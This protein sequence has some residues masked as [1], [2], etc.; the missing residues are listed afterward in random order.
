M[1]DR[2]NP[3]EQPP[4]RRAL[5][6]H[7]VGVS[8]QIGQATPAGD[9]HRACPNVL[10]GL[11]HYCAQADRIATNAASEADVDWWR[12]GGYEGFQSRVGW[13]LASAVAEPISGGDRMRRPVARL[14][15]R[16]GL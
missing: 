4:V 6:D 13:L 14:G 1:D 10:N 16:W 3:R 9:D 5:D 8:V 2:G 7:G 12:V 11:A 15:T